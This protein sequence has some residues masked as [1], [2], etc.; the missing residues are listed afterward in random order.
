VPVVDYAAQVLS[1]LFQKWN[2]LVF[3]VSF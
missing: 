3:D 1:G 2:F